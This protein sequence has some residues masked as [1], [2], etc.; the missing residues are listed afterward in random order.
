MAGNAMDGLRS[1]ANPLSLRTIVQNS[2]CL[3]E[4][5]FTTPASQWNALIQLKLMFARPASSNTGARGWPEFCQHMGAD[6]FV[7]D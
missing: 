5:S 3:T 6:D 1:M 4:L 2:T 7:C